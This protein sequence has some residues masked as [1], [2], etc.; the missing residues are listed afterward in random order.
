MKTVTVSSII[1]EWFL[2]VR[3]P[4]DHIATGNFN[5]RDSVLG[6]WID[7]SRLDYLVHREGSTSYIATY[8]ALYLPSIGYQE[9]T[10]VVQE[11]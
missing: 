8:Q 10:V 9:K 4:F 11:I 2:K 5:H 3:F 1:L 7:T 6:L